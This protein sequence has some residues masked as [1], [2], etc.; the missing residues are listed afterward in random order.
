MYL[1]LYW[2]QYIIWFWSQIKANGRPEAEEN[3]TGV[4]SVF[5]KYSLRYRRNIPWAPSST[6]NIDIPAGTT[7]LS[8]YRFLF[9]FLFHIS[10]ILR[11]YNYPLHDGFHIS[12]NTAPAQILQIWPTDET[13]NIPSSPT[14]VISSSQPINKAALLK[15]LSVYL[16]LCRKS[17]D[18]SWFVQTS[19]KQAS[20]VAEIQCHVWDSRRWGYSRG[21]TSLVSRMKYE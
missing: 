1:Q 3:E 18:Y 12:F 4:W 2:L 17:I 10:L 5:D 13:E 21:S 19:W 20:H 9:A 7:G 14:V 16:T 8:A 6:Y 11:I 15:K